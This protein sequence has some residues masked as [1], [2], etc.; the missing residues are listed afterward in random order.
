M[1]EEACEILEQE[2]RECTYSKREIASVVLKDLANL[3][4]HI[5]PLEEHVIGYL[6]SDSYYPGK[7]ARIDWIAHLDPIEII[8]RVLVTV[9]SKKSQSI[10]AVVGC[11]LPW[12]GYEDTR[13]GL[14]TATEL[15]GVCKRSGLYSINKP[16]KSMDGSWISNVV[17]NVEL[18]KEVYQFID[19][20][21]YMPPMT[22][23]PKEVN[24]NSETGYLNPNGSLLLN[25]A[26]HEEEI[27]LDV[28]N[29][30]SSIA[31]NINED[32]IKFEEPTPDFA[33]TAEEE[34]KSLTAL[35]L[36]EATTNF[37]VHRNQTECLEQELIGK[38]FYF[39]YK[40]DSR[41]RLY[42]QGY[43]ITYQGTKYKKSCIDLYN[44]ELTTEEGIRWLY[45]DI[46]NHYGLDKES[47][48]D[49]KLWVA[50]NYDDLEDFVDSA[51]NPYM[52]MKAVRA[53]R[54]ADNNEPTGHLVALDSTASFL[55]IISILAGC[56]TTAEQCN[57]VNTGKR[58]DF[59]TNLTDKMNEFLDG[60]HTMDRQRVKDAA[61]PM[62]YG[63]IAA[64]IR[65]F[66][67]ET[68][69]LAAFFK[70]V[71]ILAPSMNPVMDSIQ[72]CWDP[73]TLAHTCTYP[74]GH[75][76]RVPVTESVTY[77]GIKGDEYPYSFTYI[78]E[79]TTPST[80]SIPILSNVIQGYDAYIVR[81][82]IR[83]CNFDVLTVHDEFL[84]HPNNMSELREVYRDIL[85][86]LAEEDTLSDILSSLTGYNIKT[87][88]FSIDLADYIRE[89][90]YFLS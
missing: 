24:S 11:L 45:V 89:A 88:K 76:S 74:D 61:I 84:T 20:T 75:V 63:S 55:A 67:E 9:L 49:R 25:G 8:E 29:K 39:N 2:I 21:M 71:D 48:T 46:A 13:D 17:S 73:T 44:K 47:F 33:A 23:K 18:S 87:G 1:Y 51:E 37:I 16:T 65:V 27:S 59:Y 85:I 4:E 10:Q 68:E 69:E 83:R 60:S 57:L 14:N 81:E 7:R 79:E 78:C 40:F 80:Y 62:V 53:L 52:Y 66:G 64:P 15:V 31:L 5:I 28:I 56:K 36:K 30:Q 32:S 50:H 34:G 35:Q 82:V 38:P 6:Q 86:E 54:E 70:A 58:E 41:G 43:H 42:N 26:H 3:K 72:S 22:I 12:L 19:N 77:K 90:E